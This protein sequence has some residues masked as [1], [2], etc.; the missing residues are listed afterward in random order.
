MTSLLDRATG[1]R[2]DLIDLRRDLH[3][4]P[5]LAFCETRTAGAAAR[6]VEAGD[7]SKREAR[8]AE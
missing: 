2:N 8:E 6:A 1:F 4:H 5:E 7:R 3:R